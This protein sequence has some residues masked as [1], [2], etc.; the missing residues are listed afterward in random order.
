MN[1]TLTKNSDLGLAIY[2]L[3]VS[4]GLNIFAFFNIMDAT[5]L[6]LKAVLASFGAS[7]VLLQADS[8][9]KWKF[10]K[11]KST[12]TS[13]ILC[14][15]ISLFSTCY[16]ITALN[17]ENGHEVD[18]K[19]ENVSSTIAEEEGNIEDHKE[20]KKLLFMA[21]EEAKAS[22]RGLEEDKS[23]YG[24]NYYT[25]KS[26]ISIKIDEKDEE[27]QNLVDK[28]K[29][30]NTLI[31]QSKDKIEELRSSSTEVVSE[32]KADIFLR[33]SRATN[34]P[35]WFVTV[36]PFLLL[37]IILELGI[38]ILTPG[39]EKKAEGDPSIIKTL[40]Q[41]LKDKDILIDA[42]E[43]ELKD[44][45]KPTMNEYIDAIFSTN[46]KKLASKEDAARVTGFNLRACDEYHYT[47]THTL[48]N[49]KKTFLET[50]RGRGTFS[51]YSKESIKEQL[52][53]LKKTKKV[54]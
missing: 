14:T 2:F 42:L 3:L 53:E 37:G 47:L 46:W 30:T 15:L 19:V 45:G 38:F 52:K 10:H 54:G 1:N 6:I 20:S 12:F 18:T 16:L 33:I 32:Q 7:L 27:I 43:L 9:R 34:T 28:I 35:R 22:K 50:A 5:G 25:K 21:I 8:L 44:L 23:F 17:V 40:T 31:R 48:G 26:E 39:L 29:D 49:K 41:T 36:I 11:T 24:D 13:Y 51:V 4:L